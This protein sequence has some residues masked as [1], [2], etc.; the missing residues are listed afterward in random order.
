MT[1]MMKVI[2]KRIRTNNM[3]IIL[4]WYKISVK[5]ATF[6][7][8]SWQNHLYF[9]FYINSHTVNVRIFCLSNC[10][11][12]PYCFNM[13]FNYF[14]N[15]FV[16]KK[17]LWIKWSERNGYCLNFNFVLGKSIDG[18]SI[19]NVTKILTLKKILYSFNEWV[20]W[21]LQFCF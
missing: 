5:Y 6:I 19:W 14:Y 17:F 11:R 2:G 16:P 13:K 3:Y 4:S 7:I 9:I 15:R 21:I 8:K 1:I 20:P 12:Y 18:N 10:N